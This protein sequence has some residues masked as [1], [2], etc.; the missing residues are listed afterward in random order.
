MGKSRNTPFNRDPEERWGKHNSPGKWAG[1]K[2]FNTEHNRRTRQKFKQ[3]VRN[4]K[5]WEDLDDQPDF[6]D[7]R[8]RNQAK[9]DFF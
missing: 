4:A 2:A 8:P 1:I 7:F 9:W 5:D 6:E 3:S